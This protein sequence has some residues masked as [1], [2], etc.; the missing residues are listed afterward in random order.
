[1]LKSYGLTDKGL[2]RE[3]NEDAFYISEEQ[4]VYIVSDGMGGHF[5]G[6]IASKIVTELLPRLIDKY[7]SG[8]DLGNEKS[9]E[10][11]KFA[12]TDLNN[13][14]IEHTENKV[15]L[16]GMGATLVMAICRNKQLLIAHLGDSR[17]YLYRENELKCLTKDH[18]IIEALLESGDLTP[19]DVASY[20]G[21]EQ[22]T[23]FVGKKNAEPTIDLIDLKLNDK[24]LLCSDGLTGMVNDSGITNIFEK[25]SMPLDICDSAIR[26]AKKAGGKDNITA[27][28][29][30]VE[31]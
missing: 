2:I 18:S 1:M 12:I 16:D 13:K 28:V 24:I 23:Q 20:S 19:A 31:S 26:N 10:Q 5:H 14:L 17:I 6:E 7:Y 22:I 15:G 9:R 4:G 29:I 11:I 3:Q 30:A 25:Y 27:L 8:G 21:G